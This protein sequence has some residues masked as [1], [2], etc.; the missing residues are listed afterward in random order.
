MAGARQGGWVPVYGD[1]TRH[2]KTRAVAEA[3][4]V[5]RH[6]VVG[7]LV[8]LWAW[9]AVEKVPV[10]AGGPL[11]DE[12]VERAAEWDGKRGRMVEALLTAGYLDRG[13]DGLLYLHDWGDGG[14]KSV[15]A[16][17]RWARNK[18]NV[19]A[20]SNADTSED[21]RAEVSEDVRALDQTRSDQK[22]SDPPLPPHEAVRPARAKS[23]GRGG[24]PSA[25]S[26]E[27]WVRA[28][29][30]EFHGTMSP[31]TGL[32]I[33]EAL[34]R[35]RHADRPCVAEHIG[36]ADRVLAERQERERVK[37]PW[38]FWWRAFESALGSCGG[39]GRASEPES[40]PVDWEAAEAAA[41]A[42]NMAQFK[43]QRPAREA[44][45]D[46]A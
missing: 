12:D 7:H 24:A 17:V 38:R 5:S 25:E 30:A 46:G 31:D 45:S 28:K 37:V 14:G 16:K 18:R 15:K 13:E 27:A 22:R 39:G 35:T 4:R 19:R 1:V 11:Y 8:A 40:I 23:A 9:A 42:A 33:A 43:H 32:H 29:H 2:P 20:D 34:D 10:P 41:R 21:T 36:E 26:P 44:V 6:A 3:L